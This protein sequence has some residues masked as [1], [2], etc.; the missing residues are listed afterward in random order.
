MDNTVELLPLTYYQSSLIVVGPAVDTGGAAFLALQGIP[1][2]PA[3]GTWSMQ[4]QH[5]NV[6]EDQQFVNLGSAVNITSGQRG[7]F[8]FYTQFSRF[9]RLRLV[10]SGGQAGGFRAVLCMKDSN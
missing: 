8:V 4:L 7:I 6:N 9:V 10:P 1:D 2:E 5:S 3:S